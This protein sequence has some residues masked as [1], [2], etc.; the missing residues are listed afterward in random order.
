MEI[1]EIKGTEIKEVFE[2]LLEHGT[3][4]RLRVR[5][6]GY[7]H[8]TIVT[9]FRRKL[10]KQYFLADYTEGFKEAV[11][12]KKDIRAEFEFTGFED[13]ILRSF[14]VSGVDFYN[15]QLCFEFPK[16]IQRHQRRKYFRLEAPAGTVVEF[17]CSDRQCSE[18][19][20]DISLGGALIALVSFGHISR[21]ELPFGIGD[22][23]QDVTLCFPTDSGDERITVKRASVV[24]FDKGSPEADTCCGLHFI[25]IE[26]DEAQALTDFVYHYQRKYLRTRVRPDR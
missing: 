25:E 3:L 26:S 2:S 22:E 15:D 6:T 12:G 19:V 5:G 13:S 24:R 8:L 9:G 14:S 11:A 7:Q 4:V 23:L 18:K 1:E 16:V 21:K 17:N 10:N 20:V